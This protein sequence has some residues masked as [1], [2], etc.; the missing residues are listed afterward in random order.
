[1]KTMTVVLMRTASRDRS[2]HAATSRI[3][4]RGSTWVKSVTVF[5][6]ADAFGRHIGF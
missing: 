5:G 1:V 3:V 4:E 6:E 2:S